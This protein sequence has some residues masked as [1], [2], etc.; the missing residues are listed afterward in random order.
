MKDQFL[1]EEHT[2]IRSVAAQKKTVWMEPQVGYRI[3]LSIDNLRT[4]DEAFQILKKLVARQKN[5]PK[6]MK[7]LADA[8]PEG[9]LDGQSQMI[10]TVNL[11]EVH[12]SVRCFV[13]SSSF[14]MLTN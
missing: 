3:K 6:G 2:S 10:D 4:S 8:I 9:Y 11:Q 13:L 5:T 1:L 7:Q 12:N 14:T